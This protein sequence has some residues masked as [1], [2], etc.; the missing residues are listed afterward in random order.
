MTADQSSPLMRTARPSRVM[1]ALRTTASSG[2]SASS[3]ASTRPWAWASSETSA[4]S[5]TARRPRASTAD[6]VVGGPLG[7]GRVAHRDVEAVGGQGARDRGADATAGTRDE[8]D[9]H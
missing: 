5:A 6:T 8:R 3:A 7:V 9:R 1:P 2:P 4:C